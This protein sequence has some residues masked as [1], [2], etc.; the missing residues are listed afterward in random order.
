[1]R[2]LIN[3]ISRQIYYQIQRILAKF[4]STEFARRMK[5]DEAYFDRLRD[6]LVQAQSSGKA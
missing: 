6:R 3:I 5:E 1:M 4:E 2:G